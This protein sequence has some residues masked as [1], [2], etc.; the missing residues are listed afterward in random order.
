MKISVNDKELFTLS[1]IQKQ[2]IKNDI[3]ENIFEEDMNR[4][5]QWVLMHKY[6][7]CF[8]RLKTE[9]DQ[10]LAANGVQMIPTDADAY[11]QLVFSQPNYKDRAA[12]DSV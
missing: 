2:V 1:D 12:R 3:P 8:G 4:R 9:W 10:K 7:Q 11:A 6:E 5:L